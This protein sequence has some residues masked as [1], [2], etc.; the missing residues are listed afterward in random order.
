MD[1]VVFKNLVQKYM[2][3]TYLPQLL[4]DVQQAA[5]RYI[6]VRR[7]HEKLAGAKPNDME[8]DE[9]RQAVTDRDKTRTLAHNNLIACINIVNRQLVAKGYPL[10]MEPQVLD[11]RDPEIRQ[12][13]YEFAKDIL[14]K[15][16]Q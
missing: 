10:L 7:A 15:S 8:G 2:G 16:P 13:V 11:E 14:D 9:Y 6:E 4:E 1:S 12:Q 5:I 3:E